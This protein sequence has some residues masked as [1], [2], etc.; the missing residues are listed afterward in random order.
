MSDA[1][2]FLRQM[3]E[4]VRAEIRGELYKHRTAPGSG[5]AVWNEYGLI[6]G[7]GVGGGV[8]AL[9]A[10]ARRIGSFSLT[11][12]NQVIPYNQ[13]DYDPQSTISDAGSASWLFTA[14]QAG[15]YLLSASLTANIRQRTTDF[16]LDEYAL[17]AN[18]V[19]LYYHAGEVLPFAD[20]PFSGY[21]TRQ[22][23]GAQVVSLAAGAS[24]AIKVRL[25]VR[26]D[27]ADAASSYIPTTY[28]ASAGSNQFSVV[29]LGA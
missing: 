12:I 4:M 19:S 3:R 25:L 28:L 17:S 10:V 9:I 5:S 14:P 18:N 27:G 23:Y 7:K 13:I 20:H 8:G 21:S 11:T 29:Y 2:R 16:W 22:A 15:K 26:N 24:V 6:T 1:D